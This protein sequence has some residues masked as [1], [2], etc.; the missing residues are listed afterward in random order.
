MQEF[1][2]D[3][4]VSVLNVHFRRLIK[5]RLQKAKK[6]YKK[7]TKNLEQNTIIG[8]K[9]T[10]YTAGQRYDDGMRILEALSA[11][12]LRSIRYAKEV[13]GVREIV[14]NDLSKHA[15]ESIRENVQHNKV[16]HL[17]KPSHADAM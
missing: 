6:G 9:T 3:L 14:A 1:N 8:D 15:V 7:Q 10:E 5:E 17:I 2:R 16:D 11:T 12:G 13:A 4:S